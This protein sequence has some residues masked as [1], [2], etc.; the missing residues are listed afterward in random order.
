M[1]AEHDG[2]GYADVESRLTGHARQG[3]SIDG[4]RQR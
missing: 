4:G 2:G 1:A 3:Q